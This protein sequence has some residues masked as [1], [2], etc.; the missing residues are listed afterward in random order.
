ME[1]N[2]NDRAA[3]LHHPVRG[4]RRVD[5][6][7]QQA[8]HPPADA[9]RQPAGARLLAE[10]VERLVWRASRHGWSARDDRD[11]PASR[12]ARLDARRRLRARSA[13]E[14]IGNRLSP[15]VARHAEADGGASPRGPRESPPRAPRSRAARGRPSRSSRCRTRARRVRVTSVTAAVG[16]STI[17]I[18]PMSARTSFTSRPRGRCPQVADQ[19]ADEPRAVLPLERDFL[20]V[21]D[22][23]SHG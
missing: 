4:D 7:R 3:A 19:L 11:R 14:V 23:G 18:R 10:G 21:D 16:P 2:Q 20:V 9:G 6:A 22:D 1:M 12:R 8:R 17:S 5:A 13:G 15:R